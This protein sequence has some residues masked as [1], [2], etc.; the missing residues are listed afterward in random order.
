MSFEEEDVF[1]LKPTLIIKRA[2]TDLFLLRERERERERERK[3]KRD[4]GRE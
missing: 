2:R 4:K 1:I 3:R